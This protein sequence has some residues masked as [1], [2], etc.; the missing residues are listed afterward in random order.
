MR[1]PFVSRTRLALE[2]LGVF[3]LGLGDAGALHGRFRMREA[4]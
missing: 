2:T 1:S 4:R 3:I